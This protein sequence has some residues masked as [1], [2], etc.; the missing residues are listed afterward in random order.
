[1]ELRVNELNGLVG[2]KIELGIVIPVIISR[3]S[4]DVEEQR[5][6]DLTKCFK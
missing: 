1:M 5:E 2:N 3:R 4:A 6:W